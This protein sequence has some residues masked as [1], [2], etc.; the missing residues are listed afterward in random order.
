M[1]CVICIDNHLYNLL[2]HGLGWGVKYNFFPLHKCT[3]Y[4]EYMQMRHWDTQRFTG[5]Q[6]LYYSCMETN[7]IF[8]KL[9]GTI[10]LQY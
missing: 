1:K 10:Q 2:P 8:C 6:H 9:G 3:A 5:E 4:F 7:N